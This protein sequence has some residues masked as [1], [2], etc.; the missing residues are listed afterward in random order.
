MTDK[1]DSLKEIER[2][3]YRSTFTDGIYDIQFGLIF[4]FL[5][6]IVV[7][8]ADGGPRLVGYA[9]LL[10]PLIMPWLGKRYITVPRMGRVEFGEK[11][12]KKRL[13]ILVITAIVLFFTLPLFIMLLQQQPSGGLGWKLIAIFI[14]PIFVLAVYTT[15]FP[16]L[17]IYTGLLFAGLIEA[18]FLIKYIGSPAHALVSFGLPGLVI[19]GIGIYMLISFIKTHPRSEVGY[20]E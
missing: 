7:L 2:R 15:D 12:K 1:N 3:A 16:R 5:T 20:A 6:L 18:E 14:A 10:I 9:L 11:R 17:Y 4:L 8:E 19:T 13:V